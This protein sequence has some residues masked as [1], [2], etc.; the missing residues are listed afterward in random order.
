MVVEILRIDIN[1]KKSVAIVEKFGIK[2]VQLQSESNRFLN[3]SVKGFS[4]LMVIANKLGNL[5]PD[6]PDHTNQSFF[7][8]DVYK[9]KAV[10]LRIVKLS[11]VLGKVPTDDD[12]TFVVDIRQYEGASF[13]QR[14]WGMCFNLTTWNIMCNVAFPKL[15][16]KLGITDTLQELICVMNGG[17]E[18]TVP[19]TQPQQPIESVDVSSDNAQIPI[20]VI[21]L[22]S[23][24]KLPDSLDMIFISD[25][26]SN[27]QSTQ[28]VDEWLRE[29]INTDVAKPTPEPLESANNSRDEEDKENRLK[30]KRRRPNSWLGKMLK[31]SKADDPGKLQRE[32]YDAVQ[33]LSNLKSSK[34]KTMTMIMTAYGKKVMETS[35]NHADLW[36]DDKKS[37]VKLFEK[38]AIERGI[39]E[40]DPVGLYEYCAIHYDKDIVSAM[41]NPGGWCELEKANFFNEVGA[42]AEGERPTKRRSVSK[43]KN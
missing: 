13:C 42:A 34:V 6:N 25:D 26:E 3:L 9:N 29:I 4:N 12:D 8:Q 32:G 24:D 40:I 21:T 17:A 18:E 37:M 38:V 5:D 16:E 20:E 7:V 30:R 31:L 27:D 39:N 1:K 10:Y 14:G 22:D 19:F 28:V 33:K 35:G 41:R 36:M 11:E 23:S 15:R 43:D 2:R